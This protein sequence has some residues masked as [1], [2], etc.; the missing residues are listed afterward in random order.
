M[1]TT[2]DV[3]R[4][5]FL[6]RTLARILRLLRLERFNFL[7]HHQGE[8][9]DVRRHVCI[10]RIQPKLIKLVRRCALWIQPNITALRLTEFRTVGFLDER[11]R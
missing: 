9:A 10:T 4:Q 5:C 2:R 6:H 11:C 1:H 7:S 3:F 8:Y